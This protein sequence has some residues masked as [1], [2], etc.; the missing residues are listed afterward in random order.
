LLRGGQVVFTDHDV[1]F[2][3]TKPADSVHITDFIR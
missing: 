2:R 3:I 1:G